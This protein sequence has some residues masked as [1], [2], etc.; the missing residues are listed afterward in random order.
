MKEL[1]Q[2][3]YLITHK[4]RNEQY[5]VVLRGIAPLLRITDVVNLTNLSILVIFV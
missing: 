4:E 2:G 3:V 1:E 5:I